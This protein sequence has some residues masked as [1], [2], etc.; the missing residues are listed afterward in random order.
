MMKGL[1]V[2]SFNFYHPMRLYAGLIVFTLQQ[3]HVAH[4]NLLKVK[5]SYS[6]SVSIYHLKT[7]RYFWCNCMQ[8]IYF[9]FVSY[10][11]YLPVNGH[12]VKRNSGCFMCRWF[13]KCD[14]ILCS[15]IYL[16]KMYINGLSSDA[17]SKLR[18]CSGKQQHVWTDVCILV[19]IYCAL[20][21]P[22][23]PSLC[24]SAKGALFGSIGWW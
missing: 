18:L 2:W 15:K 20:E 5:L 24:E 14:C 11:T 8:L 13:K 21:L 1:F 22:L 6:V 7:C 16:M 10:Y 23:F 19:R 9:T 3:L 17:V 4:L 12:L